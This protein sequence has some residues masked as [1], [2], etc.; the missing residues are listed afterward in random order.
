MTL[1][2]LKCGGNEFKETLTGYDGFL[3]ACVK[4]NGI[5]AVKARYMQPIFGQPQNEEAQR[6][7]RMEKKGAVGVS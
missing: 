1:L 5:L 3:R 4:R 7:D 6:P 2:T